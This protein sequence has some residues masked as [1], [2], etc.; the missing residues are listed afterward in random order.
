[1]VPVRDDDDEQSQIQSTKHDTLVSLHT[2]ETTPV[3]NGSIQGIDANTRVAWVCGSRNHAWQRA[4]RLNGIARVAALKKVQARIAEAPAAQ[5]VEKDLYN[6]CIFPFEL[7]SPVDAAEL[8]NTVVRELKD[9]LRNSL[10]GGYILE[11]HAQRKP[12]YGGRHQQPL[13]AEST[14][15]AV[16]LRKLATLLE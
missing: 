4:L 12:V 6:S 7:F 13:G 3:D 5:I 15:E 8:T 10:Q 14:L 9:D 1:M 2:T 11:G 16:S